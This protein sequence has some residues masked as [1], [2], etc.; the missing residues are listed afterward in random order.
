[1]VCGNSFLLVRSVHSNPLR[2]R[3][4]RFE[5]CRGAPERTSGYSNRPAATAYFA[6]CHPL[7]GCDRKRRV[8]TPS[9]PHTLPKMTVS[10][11]KHRELLPAKPRRAPPGVATRRIGAPLATRC[12]TVAGQKGFLSRSMCPAQAEK[13]GGWP[14]HTQS[15]HCVAEQSRIWIKAAPLRSAAGPAPAPGLRPWGAPAGRAPGRRTNTPQISQAHRQYTVHGASV[16]PDPDCPARGR[17]VKG[18]PAGRRSRDRLHRPWTRL[19]LAWD[20]RL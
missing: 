18:G 13:T 15:P 7:S 8:L 9:A 19:P 2:S 3:E 10:A 1:M 6:G 17:R 4:R 12:V 16:F 14:Q 20:R 5:S 11:A